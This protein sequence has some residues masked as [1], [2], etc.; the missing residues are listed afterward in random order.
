MTDKNSHII[1]TCFG[2]IL[3]DH[4]SHDIVEI[5]NHIVTIHNIEPMITDNTDNFSP[6]SRQYYLCNKCD[7]KCIKRSDYL[8]HCKTKKHN[9]VVDVSSFVYECGKTYKHR[10]SLHSHRLLCKRR[11]SDN[12]TYK[13][14]PV[15]D[16]PD[17]TT[18]IVELLK[19]NQE[20]KDLIIEERKE[21][22]KLILEMAGKAGNNTN[23]HNTNSHNKFNLNLFLNEKCKDAITMNDFIHNMEV[24]VDDFINTGNVG[25]VDG[26]SK[27][28]VDRMREMEM[29]T[30]PMHCTDL[31][32][33]TIYIKDSEKWEKDDDKRMLRNAVKYVAKK[34]HAQLR[35]WF[36]N[37]QPKVDQIGTEEYENY[38]Q[39]YKAALGG[40]GKEEDMKFEDKIMK[41]VMKETTIDKQIL[42]E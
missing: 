39:Y 12:N 1:N 13:Q 20:F 38:F 34:N 19:Q 3:C 17:N 35:T 40:C 31:K 6:N 37:S 24:T 33:E 16:Q 30:R 28:I 22:Q 9:K 29:H 32:R 4:Y 25:F 5:N 41:N 27:V 10:Q 23:S 8:K 21:F 18:L 36:D 14:E 11:K 42:L 15:Q 2:C 26:I 7:Y